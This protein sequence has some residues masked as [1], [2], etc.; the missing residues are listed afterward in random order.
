MRATK[1]MAKI[2][3]NKK[4]H[5]ASLGKNPDVIRLT[6]ELEKIKKDNSVLQLVELQYQKEIAR[7]QKRAERAR[8]ERESG[9][10]IIDSPLRRAREYALSIANSPSPMKRFLRD[11]RSSIASDCSPQ[12]RSPVK[13]SPEK[14]SPVKNDKSEDN[15]LVFKIK[16]T[17]MLTK[18]KT[19]QLEPIPQTPEKKKRNIST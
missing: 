5:A 16:R 3:Q 10:Q 9:E 15:E 2:E 14:Q 1:E 4:D 7:R 18:A 17:S 11:G 8:I 19:T 12:F 13:N 6:K